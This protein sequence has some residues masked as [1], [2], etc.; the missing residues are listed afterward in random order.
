MN[1]IYLDYG[2]TL[3]H[4]TRQKFHHITLKEFD[5]PTYIQ[6]NNKLPYH[7]L[8]FEPRKIYDQ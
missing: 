5:W 6:I 4:V 3:K 7:L 1:R 2:Y 8:Q